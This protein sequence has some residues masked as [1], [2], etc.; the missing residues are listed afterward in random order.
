[1]FMCSCGVINRIIIIIISSSSQYYLGCGIGCYSVIVV[2]LERKR[3]LR[4]TYWSQKNRADT[5]SNVPLPLCCS[6]SG[7]PT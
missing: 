6:C 3:G 7:N 1:M 4:G 2:R 5:G